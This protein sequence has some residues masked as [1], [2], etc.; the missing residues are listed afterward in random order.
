M[1]LSRKDLKATFGFGYGSAVTRIL[2]ASFQYET[3]AQARQFARK[4]C[5][6]NLLDVMVSA[7]G[8]L[9]LVHFVG[10][11]FC[12]ASRSRA[13]HASYDRSSDDR[14]RSRSRHSQ[15]SLLR[16]QKRLQGSD[17]IFFAGSF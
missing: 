11:Q 5:Q 8:D 14:M 13:G 17:H 7:S 1:G 2:I 3:R 12:R 10:A 4:T 9:S 15:R 16:F 6:M